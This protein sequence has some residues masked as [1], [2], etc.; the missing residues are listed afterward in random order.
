MIAT[1]RE[2]LDVD[3]EHIVQLPAL[4]SSIDGPAVELFIDRASSVD[5]D[6]QPD[7]ATRSTIATLCEHLDGI[8]LAI[9]L[10][11]SRVTVMTPHEMMERIH[12]RFRLLSGG[13]RRARHRQSTLEAALDWSYEPRS[14]VW[15]LPVAG[16]AWW[17]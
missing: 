3:G 4:E 11:A 15:W 8:P 9:E 5:P 12:D 13:R 6:F 10:A 14:T 17:A 7:A 2:F 16:C 1:S